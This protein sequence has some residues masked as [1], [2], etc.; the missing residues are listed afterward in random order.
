[1]GTGEGTGAGDIE[2][3]TVMVV[4]HRW[5]GTAQRGTAGGLKVPNG[6]RSRNLDPLSTPEMECE[7]AGAGQSPVS[8]W[9]DLQLGQGM[10]VTL[11]TSFSTGR[12]S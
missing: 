12:S 10:F 5:G 6:P 11:H 2:G 9:P 8:A 1:M 4:L 3:V 7:P